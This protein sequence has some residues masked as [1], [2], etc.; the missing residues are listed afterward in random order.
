MLVSLGNVDFRDAVGGLGGGVLVNRLVGDGLLLLGRV[1][2]WGRLVRSLG[3]DSAGGVHNWSVLGWGL[4]ENNQH[5][6]FSV[7]NSATLTG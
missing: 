2:V 4:N 3:W 1:W 6:F 7:V 5:A